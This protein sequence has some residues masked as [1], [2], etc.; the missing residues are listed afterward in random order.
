VRKIKPNKKSQLNLNKLKK[1]VIP[2]TVN[3]PKT[4]RKMNKKELMMKKEVKN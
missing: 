2:V 1:M 3:L 4:S